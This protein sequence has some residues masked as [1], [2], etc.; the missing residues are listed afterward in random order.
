[1]WASSLPKVA[2]LGLDRVRM[3]VSFASSAASSII[4]AI[5]IVPDVDP[6]LMVR[7]PLAKV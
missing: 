5:V 2:L 4:L 3:T 6:A 7:V 1:M